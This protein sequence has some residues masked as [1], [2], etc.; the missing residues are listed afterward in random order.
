MRRNRLPRW[1]ASRESETLSGDSAYEIEQPAFGDVADSALK[2]TAL[3][4]PVGD[5]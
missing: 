1:S 3:A 4:A 5:S 2:K